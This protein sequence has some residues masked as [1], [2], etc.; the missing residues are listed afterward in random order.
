VKIDSAE[1]LI[2]EPFWGGW[3]VAMEQVEGGQDL[4][5]IR[6]PLIS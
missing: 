6:K 5:P 3:T 1:K 4:K 2:V